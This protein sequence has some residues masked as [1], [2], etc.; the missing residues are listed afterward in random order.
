MNISDTLL[1]KVEKPARYIGNEVNAINKTVEDIKIHFAL[2][3]PDVYEIGMSHLGL[4]ILYF[5]LNRRDDVYCE[6]CFAVWN[7]MESV[8]RENKIPLFSLETKAN[9]KEFDFVGFTLQYE[10]SYTNII[11]M[12]DLAYIPIYSCDRTENDPIICGGGPCTYNPEPMAEIFDFFY[13]GEGEAALDEIMDLYNENKANG[14]TRDDF[15]EMLLNVEG[16]YV[17]KFYDVSYKLDGSIDS[18]VPNNPQAKTKIRKVIAENLDDY[19]FLEKQIVPLIEVVHDRVT[20]EVFRGCVRGCR[21]CQAGY[22]YRP[23]R[24]RSCNLLL[25]QA[26]KLLDSSGHEEISLVSLST[27]DYGEFKPLAEGIIDRFEDEKVSISLPSLRIDAF[28]L[29]LMEKV[30]N[31]RKSSLTF[32]PEAG[33]QRLRNVINK[34]ITED[35]ILTG[36]GI[37]FAGGWNRIKLYFMLGLPTETDQDLEGIVQLSEKIVEKYYE[38]GNRK[39]SPSVTMST[40]CFIPKAFTPFQWDK[41]DDYETLMDKQRLIKRSLT[42]RQIR[43]S[44]HCA[45]TSVMEAIM[46]RGDRQVIRAI[47]KAWG[48]GARF[49]GWTEFFKYDL[50]LDAFEKTSIDITKYLRERNYDEILPWEHIDIGVSKEFLINERKKAYEEKTTSHCRI[51]CVGCGADSFLGGACFGE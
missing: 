44:Y 20:L 2:C 25:E 42:K 15:L 11:N 29:E 27:G 30:Q 3:F 43:Y 1:L 24:E 48:M 34:G 10:M 39:I 4:Q 47:V 36:S 8:M 46:S 19:F 7:D 14:G 23:V 28:N 5:F 49:D 32:A 12:L 38:V 40:S 31:V 51:A 45:G 6:R 50:W 35:E 18:F 21:F 22:V 16:V 26:G 33:T 37:A 41:Q 9:L 13:I 17:P